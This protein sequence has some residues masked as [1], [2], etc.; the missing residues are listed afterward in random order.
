MGFVYLWGM[1][2]SPHCCAFERIPQ[3]E[4][5]HEVRH[6][7]AGLKL[8]LRRTQGQAVQCTAK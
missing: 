6:M 1:Q 3:S 2:V 4:I 8:D 7:F 5:L